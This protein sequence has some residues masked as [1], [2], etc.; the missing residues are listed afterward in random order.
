MRSHGGFPGKAAI[1]FC[2]ETRDRPKTIIF[3]E[4]VVLLESHGLRVEQK[5]F[6]SSVIGEIFKTNELFVD[7]V[8]FIFSV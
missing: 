4:E 3:F 2:N 6:I 8:D 1:N 7:L 5:Y